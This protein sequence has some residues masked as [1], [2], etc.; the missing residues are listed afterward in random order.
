MLFKHPNP[1]WG[2]GQSPALRNKVPPQHRLT[3]KAK[4][5]DTKPK[6]VSKK[7]ADS[8]FRSAP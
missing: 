7:A 1:L 3:A 2:V 8:K 5:V 6:K 4:K